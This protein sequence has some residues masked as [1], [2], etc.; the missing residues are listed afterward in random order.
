M[1]HRCITGGEIVNA[2]SSDMSR[3]F[4]AGGEIV[5]VIQ[6]DLWLWIGKIVYLYFF[7]IFHVPFNFLA[8]L[9]NSI[10]YNFVIRSY[11]LLYN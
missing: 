7:F 4:I 11:K 3:R 10:Q 9:Q 1:S 8:M 6:L 5:K 2:V